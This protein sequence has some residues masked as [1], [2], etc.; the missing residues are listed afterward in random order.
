MKMKKENTCMFLFD[1]KALRKHYVFCLIIHAL[2]EMRNISFFL[3]KLVTFARKTMFFVQA[4]SSP[5]KRARHLIYSTIAGSFYPWKVL[6]VY[7]RISRQTSIAF[8]IFRDWS[9]LNIFFFSC[10]PRGCL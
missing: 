10:C 6:G 4:L 1:P 2:Q 3:H 8:F 7:T 5:I 9:L